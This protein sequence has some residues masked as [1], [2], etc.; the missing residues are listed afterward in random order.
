MPWAPHPSGC[1]EDEVMHRPHPQQ[2]HRLACVAGLGAKGE[3]G[4]VDDSQQAGLD[5]RIKGNRVDPV[6]RYGIWIL[7]NGFD[8]EIEIR[9][10]Q[11]RLDAGGEAGCRSRTCGH[12]GI[13]IPLPHQSEPDSLHPTPVAG[14]EYKPDRLPSRSCWQDLANPD[15]R[16]PISRQGL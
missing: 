11:Q 15:D 10:R 3:L 6:S 12:D 13:D 5:T 14:S 7:D 2:V 8:A 9:A 1:G 16:R 4:A